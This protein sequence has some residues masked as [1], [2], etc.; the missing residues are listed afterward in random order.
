MKQFSVCC[1]FGAAFLTWSLRENRT[2]GRWF[3]TVGF[4][5]SEKLAEFGARRRRGSEKV[6]TEASLS[7]EQLRQL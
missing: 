4:P 1:A 6:Q 2:F 5:L 7:N 3:A